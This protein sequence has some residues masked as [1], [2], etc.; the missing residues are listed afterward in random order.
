MNKMRHGHVMAS[1][2]DR[3][4]CV[5]DFAV[6]RLTEGTVWADRHPCFNGVVTDAAQGVNDYLTDDGLQRL[7]RDFSPRI[8]RALAAADSE[9]EERVNTRLL[10]W[11]D[12]RV[13]D[14]AGE[15]YDAAFYSAPVMS[16][17]ERDDALL[18]F[19]D[20]LIGQWEKIAADEG[21]LG[22]LLDWPTYCAM[23]QAGGS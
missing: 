2:P 12:Q 13:P 5:M 11:L 7:D 6:W 17:R 20:E 3:G 14:A 16:S 18:A 1:G 4:G 15:P 9:R 21:A 8:D 22:D 10:A 23:H 19:L